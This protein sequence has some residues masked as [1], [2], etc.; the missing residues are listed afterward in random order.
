MQTRH[1]FTD[2]QLE[3]RDD[4]EPTIEGYF[5]VFGPEYRITDDI[6]EVV[7]PT[8]FHLDR[9]TDVRAL[10]NHD[11]TLVLGRTKAGTLALDV[12]ERGLH[13]IVRVNPADPQAMGCYERVKRGDVSQCSFGFNILDQTVERRD[14]G[15]ALFH[16]N[17]VRLF[18]VSVCTFPAY[19]DT[20][21]TAREADLRAV[22]DRQAA[23]WRQ[24]M[25]LKLKG[26][27]H[28]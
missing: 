21:I 26:E 8:A 11:T 16:L 7:E 20:E 13:G 19:E 28:A 9:D 3:T 10:I 22:L 2:A 24:S 6:S 15:G 14:D 4:S 27:E 17:D 1:L 5:S 12:D 23:A 18:E 25:R